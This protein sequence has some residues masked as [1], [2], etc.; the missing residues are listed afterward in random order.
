MNI[1][2]GKDLGGASVVVIKLFVVAAIVF[3]VWFLCSF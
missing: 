2:E 1:H 3:G